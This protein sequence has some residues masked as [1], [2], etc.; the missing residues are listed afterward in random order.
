M[1]KTKKGI[2]QNTVYRLSI[3]ASFDRSLSLP[4]I[5]AV[6]YIVPYYTALLQ[7]S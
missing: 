4:K 5:Y 2:R 1:P 6:R 3:M 7:K